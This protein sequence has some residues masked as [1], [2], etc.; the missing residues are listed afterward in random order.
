MVKFGC[1]S[2]KNW[3]NFLKRAVHNCIITNTF[4]N[5]YYFFLLMEIIGLVGGRVKISS[6]ALYNSQK[7]SGRNRTT[8]GKN[9]FQIQSD[10]NVPKKL[11]L[12]LSESASE[13]HGR[14][15]M[16]KQSKKDLD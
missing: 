1:F 11:F 16:R 7:S 8:I 6:D 10:L 4:S 13:L 2:F 3:E 9:K 15:F 5:Y 12:H 14:S